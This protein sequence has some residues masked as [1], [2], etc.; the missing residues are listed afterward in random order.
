MN[1]KSFT[2]I[3]L[4][5]VIAIIGILAGL[6][7]PAI[8]KA[9][10]RADAVSCASNLRQLGAGFISYS[11][12]FH[13][14]NCPAYRAKE[15]PERG[16]CYMGLIYEYVGNND[17]FVCPSDPE[18]HLIPCKDV[19]DLRRCSYTR[20]L[21]LCG[22]VKDGVPTKMCK[23]SKFEHPSSTANLFDL[24]N[25]SFSYNLTAENFAHGVYNDSTGRWGDGYAVRD[26]ITS[27]TK[28]HTPKD[29]SSTNKTAVGGLHSG[30]FNASFYD[31]H[32]ESNFTT[33]PDKND[34][35]WKFGN[36]HID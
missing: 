31:G 11:N 20:C 24:S 26:C 18:E 1:K 27:S 6:L 28:P 25:C 33:I 9:R 13:R 22:R 2:L 19:D 21:Q 14:Y 16:P 23:M 36:E 7:L 34:D 17:V 32:V 35:F 3:E 29:N 15:N 12:D 8:G 30:A 10:D 5:V 4:L